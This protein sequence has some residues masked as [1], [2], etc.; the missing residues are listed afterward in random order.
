MSA[1]FDRDAL[2]DAFDKIGRVAALAGTKLQIAFYGGSALM[3]ARRRRSVFG[4][5]VF[6]KTFWQE[7]SYR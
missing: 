2:P 5:R 3:L 4:Q 6:R 1:A 7:W